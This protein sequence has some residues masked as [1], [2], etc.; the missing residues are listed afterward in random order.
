M[1]RS[2]WLLTLLL[3]PLLSVGQSFGS[4]VDQTSSGQAPAYLHASTTPTIANTQTLA[5]RPLQPQPPRFETELKQFSK[6]LFQFDPLWVD[7]DPVIVQKDQFLLRVNIGPVAFTGRVVP[8][9]DN[10]KVSEFN[11][12][13]KIS[14]FLEKRRG[15]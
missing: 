9:G 14:L 10:K 15:N 6:H 4:T 11:M 5:S 13:T 7:K 3:S 8:R 12:A 1:H 2:V